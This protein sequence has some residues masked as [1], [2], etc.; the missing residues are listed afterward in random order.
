MS[1]KGGAIFL[2]GLVAFY[3]VVT[4]ATP[5][6][7]GNCSDVTQHISAIAVDVTPCPE[8]PCVFEK[9]TNVTCT[10]SFTPT[11]LVSNGTLKVYGSLGPVKVLFPLPNPNACSDHGLT[12]PLKSGV[13]VKLTI[14]LP[15]KSEYPSATVL[16]EFKLEDQGNNDVFCFEIPV[17]IEDADGNVEA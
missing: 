8:Q 7:F 11:E 14:T 16:V 4:K 10:I 17:K 1:L 2:L 12:C 15:V 6:N 9:G 5:V 3:G 13:P